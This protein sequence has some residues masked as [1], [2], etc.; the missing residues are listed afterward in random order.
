MTPEKT[1]ERMDGN[2][3]M[4]KSGGIFADSLYAAEPPGLRRPEQY[5]GKRAA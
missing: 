1:H 4:E 5:D 2:E 3:E